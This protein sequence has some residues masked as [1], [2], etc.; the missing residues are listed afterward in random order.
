MKAN[1]TSEDISIIRKARANDLGIYTI[2]IF[3]ALFF[4]FF[5]LLGSKKAEFFE[6]G[7]PPLW[8]SCLF[9]ISSIGLMLNTIKN[10]L[11]YQI[12]IMRSYKLV[13]VANCRKHTESGD[14]ADSHY[15]VIEDYGKIDLFGYNKECYLNS[16]YEQDKRYEI[17]LAPL[18]KVLLSV[19]Y[20]HVAEDRDILNS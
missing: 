16:F 20:I 11:Y 1:L 8:V 3:A 7:P 5:T 12:D 10:I 13:M 19:R 15:L 17:H 18:S 6:D 4:F 2:M 14:G 9:Y